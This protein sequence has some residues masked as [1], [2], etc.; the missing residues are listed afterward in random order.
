[1]SQS[2]RRKGELLSARHALPAAWALGFAAAGFF[3]CVD[4]IRAL[5]YSAVLCLGLRGLCGPRDPAAPVLGVLAVAGA[6]VLALGVPVNLAPSMYGQMDLF[7]VQRFWELAS[8]WSGPLYLGAVLLG[9]GLGVLLPVSRT[10]PWAVV[11]LVAS[12]CWNGLFFDGELYR[13]FSLRPSRSVHD[14]TDVL[15]IMYSLHDGVPYYQAVWDGLRFKYTEVWAYRQPLLYSAWTLLPGDFRSILYAYLALGSACALAAWDLVRRQAGIPA[16]LLAA[17]M[18][19][20]LYFKGLYT[21]FPTEHEFWAAFLV[22]GALMALDRGRW[23]LAPLLLLVAMLVREQAGVFMVGFLALAL[24]ERRRWPA[25]VG[26][27][28]LGLWG[29]LYALHAHRVGMTL[30]SHG[31]QAGGGLVARS[32]GGPAFIWRT[33]EFGG[34]A[35]AGHGVYMAAVLVGCLIVVCTPGR[36]PPWVLVSLVGTGLCLA[37]F[38]VLGSA[39]NDYWGA[40]YLPTAMTLCALLFVQESADTAT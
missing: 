35:L 34:T 17:Q 6:L 7:V 23:C 30:V 31:M 1:M 20:A 22:L 29:G 25:A 10:L 14:T 40:L 36:R 21:F 26:L 5:L 19:L 16:A 38:L 33:L 3:F 13:L 15:R 8:Q 2:L 4:P 11:G 18:V 27:M 32:Q 28:G 9:I 39:A 24:R 37:A 12:A